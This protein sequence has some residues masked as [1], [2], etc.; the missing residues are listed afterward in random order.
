MSSLLPGDTIS[1]VSCWNF[2]GSG[3]IG[4]GASVSERSRHGCESE[5]SVASVSFSGGFHR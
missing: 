2:G 3:G 4:I 5:T 1:V